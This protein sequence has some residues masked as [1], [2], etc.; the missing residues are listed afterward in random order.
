MGHLFKFTEKK[1]RRRA[2]GGNFVGALLSGE[3]ECHNTEA[4]RPMQ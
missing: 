4:A 2:F 1:A 3:N